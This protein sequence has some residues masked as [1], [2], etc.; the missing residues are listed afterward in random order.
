LCRFRQLEYHRHA[1]RAR[2]FAAN[3]E[4]VE[5]P[6]PHLLAR[7]VESLGHFRAE[8]RSDL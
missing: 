4:P 3:G 7:A 8:A 6:A 5:E 2:G 1:R